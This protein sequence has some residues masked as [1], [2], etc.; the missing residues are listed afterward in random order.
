MSRS[1]RIAKARRDGTQHDQKSGWVH[2]TT[3][4]HQGSTV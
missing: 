4:P 1:R 2:L 3:R